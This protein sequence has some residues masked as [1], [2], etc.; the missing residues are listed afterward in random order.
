MRAINRYLVTETR[1]LAI[2]AD[3]AAEAAMIATVAFKQKLHPSA[4]RSGMSISNIN[5]VS[6]L[7]EKVR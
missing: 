4:I 1:T 3:S 6:Q 2:E 7:V 5:V